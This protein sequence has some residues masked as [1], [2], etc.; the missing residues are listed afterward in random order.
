MTTIQKKELIQNLRILQKEI[1]INALL[2]YYHKHEHIIPE[3]GYY[4][5]CISIIENYKTN[6]DTFINLLLTKIHNQFKTEQ[7]FNLSI[8]LMVSLKDKERCL[9]YLEE[10]DKHNIPIKKRTITPLIDLAY[11]RNDNPFNI[12]IMCLTNKLNI[13]LDEGDY[14]K[15]FNIF[16]NNN[17]YINFKLLFT[18]IITIIPIFNQNTIE[19]FKNNFNN[20]KVRNSVIANNRCISCGHVLGQRTIFNN[21]KSILLGIIKNDIAKNHYKFLGFINKINKY[22]K[23]D[24]ILD[25]ANIGYFKQRPDKGNPISYK[26]INLMVEH[27]EKGNKSILLFLHEKHITN[28]YYVNKWKHKNILYITDKGLN[29]DWFWLYAALNFMDTKF[30]TNDNLCDHYYQCLHQKFFKKWMDLTR[31]TFNFIKNHVILNIPKPYLIET[32]Q[33]MDG[34]HIP[35]RYKSRVSWICVT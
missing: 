18:K 27:L 21:Q 13:E 11:I 26:N 32:Q 10:M 35:Y 14:Y 7:S 8:R 29:D 22:K 15:Q 31:V 25:G 20:R 2:D 19:L 6:Y 34:Y 1:R 4:I 12:F 33:N 5:I 28:N 30:I 23:V 17:D 3:D 16:K 24:Y 9:S